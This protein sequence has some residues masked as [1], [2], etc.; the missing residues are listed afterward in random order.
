MSMLIP[1]DETDEGTEDSGALS[2]HGTAYLR[3][4]CVGAFGLAVLGSLLLAGIS[5]LRPHSLAMASFSGSVAAWEV[6]QTGWHRAVFNT[7][8]R[9]GKSLNSSAVQELRMGSF[10]QVL[11]RD[12]R[13]VRISYPAVGWTSSETVSGEPILLWDAPEANG[14]DILALGIEKFREVARVHKALEFNR[15]KEQDMLQKQK[16]RK[17]IGAWVSRYKSG[18]LQDDIK[19]GFSQEHIEQM[20]DEIQSQLVGAVNTT[21]EVMKGLSKDNATYAQDAIAKSS[22]GEKGGVLFGNVVTAID[23]Q[24]EAQAHLAEDNDMFKKQQQHWA[25]A[26]KVA[27]K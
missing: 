27:S 26:D 17:G 19:R 6:P 3:R 12:G 2:S 13:R 11:E 1:Q 8:I 24:K 21:G 14:K 5:C 15:K 4:G 10:V 25:K 23:A 9:K 16:L 18:K 20:S 22:L 7:M